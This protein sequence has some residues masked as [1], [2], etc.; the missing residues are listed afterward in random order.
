MNN[1]MKPLVWEAQKLLAGIYYAPISEDLRVHMQLCEPEDGVVEDL[2]GQ[3]MY[4]DMRPHSETEEGGPIRVCLFAI[5]YC[6]YDENKKL[7]KDV[8]ELAIIASVNEATIEQINEKLDG[9]VDGTNEVVAF[10]ENKRSSRIG[11]ATNVAFMAWCM[12]KGGLK[13][14][15]EA[16]FAAKYHTM[17]LECGI[18][19]KD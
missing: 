15:D 6:S 12:D 16:D 1:S 2:I 18:R 13:P 4:C 19:D 5:G 9:A 14:T 17:L 3:P 11:F 10:L 8:P 7:Y